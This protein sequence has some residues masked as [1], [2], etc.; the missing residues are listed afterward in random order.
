M[1]KSFRFSP[2]PSLDHCDRPLLNAALR[3]RRSVVFC[4]PGARITSSTAVPS[5]IGSSEM[6]RAS[7]T[8]PSPDDDVSTVLTAALTVTSSVSWPRLEGGVDVEDFGDVQVDV[9]TDVLAEAAERDGDAIRPRI[10]ERDAVVAFLVRS[11]RRRHA[12]VDVHDFDGRARDDAAGGVR[13]TALK[14]AAASWPVTS[15][16][17]ASMTQAPTIA[18]I[19]ERILV[20]SFGTRASWTGDGRRPRTTAK[21]V[22]V[23]YGEGAVQPRHAA[24]SAYLRAVMMPRAAAPDT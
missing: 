20:P 15:A 1:V 14:G 23:L 6:R 10:E 19:R 13:H 4:T 8:W 9:R 16:G 5:R 2:A 12:G 11:R 7:T 17:R 18:T 21:E 22:S 24:S 3:E